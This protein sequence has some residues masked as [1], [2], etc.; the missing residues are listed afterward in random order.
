VAIRE[1]TFR[2]ILA[3]VA[4]GSPVRRAL[5]AHEVSPCAFYAL[6]DRDADRAERYARATRGGCDAFADEAV[7][8]ADDP[9]IPADQKRIM[10]DTRKWLLAK[11]MPKKYGERTVIAGD[12]DS[13]ISVGIVEPKAELLRRLVA[14]TPSGGAT[15]PD[16]GTER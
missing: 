6:L 15:G 5:K 7:Q 2:A 10:V 4:A 11:R 16:S 12:A 13:P 9:L 8:I 1:K 3:E 14:G